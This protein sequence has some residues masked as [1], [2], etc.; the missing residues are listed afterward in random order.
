[1]FGGRRF[2]GYREFYELWKS[3]ENTRGNDDSTFKQNGKI[4]YAKRMDE[5]CYIR[6]SEWKKNGN[7]KKMYAKGERRKRNLSSYSANRRW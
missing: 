1:M 2:F 5:K 6:F 3:T 7:I 4:Y